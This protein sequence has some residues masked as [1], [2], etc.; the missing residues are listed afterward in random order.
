MIYLQI[1]NDGKNKIIANILTH[2]QDFTVT[3]LHIPCFASPVFW[4]LH[5]QFLNTKGKNRHKVNL[6]LRLCEFMN[7]FNFHSFTFIPQAARAGARMRLT[8][9]PTPPVLCLSTTL[10]FHSAGQG[11]RRSPESL[12]A[13]VRHTIS[14]SV[15]P[16]K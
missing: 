8:L 6:M 9:S 1:K 14:S 15:S 4:H 7:V 11:P 5:L 3:K 16:F 13:P 10:P 12:I 2:P